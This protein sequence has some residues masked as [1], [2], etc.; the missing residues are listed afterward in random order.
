MVVGIGTMGVT[1]AVPSA[2]KVAE[3]FCNAEFDWP[4]KRVVNTITAHMHGLIFMWI[5]LSEGTSTR[6]G[7]GH[8]RMNS[9]PLPSV[10]KLLSERIL[11]TLDHPL[12]DLPPQ[13]NGV[14]RLIL[15]Q[16]AEDRELRSQHVAIGNGRD[17]PPR[18][19]LD[20]LEPLPQIDPRHPNHHPNSTFPL[21]P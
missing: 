10:V 8:G 18:P 12:R 7:T 2:S 9:V 4:A 16:P 14:E 6:K 13:F 21:L 15:R 1:Y 20:L 11:P 5:L 17:H 19:R 3:S